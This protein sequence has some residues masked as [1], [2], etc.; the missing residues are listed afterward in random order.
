MKHTYTLEGMTCGGC[1]ASVEKHLAAIPGVT[2]ISV[3][4]ENAE[5]TIT[6]ESHISISALKEA[7]PSK[8]IISEKN[9]FKNTSVVTATKEEKTKLQ[10]LKPLLLIFFFITLIDLAINYPKFVLSD[11]MLDFMGLFFM[12]FSLFKFFDLKGFATSFSMYDP[13]AKLV[14]P[15]AY[16]YPFVELIL[17]VFFL[18]RV[19]IPV[20][21]LVTLVVLFITTIG[22]TRSLFGKETIQCACLGT[23]LELP[24]TEATFI[25]NTIMILMAIVMIFE[26]V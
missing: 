19:E 13:L 1:K 15:Y 20:M 10:Q 5:A 8:Y 9:I 21:L 4:L 16:V 24:M 7:L 26:W 2:E 3:S 6:S 12:V 14:K 17:G 22:V 25:E 18:M 23:V 11:L